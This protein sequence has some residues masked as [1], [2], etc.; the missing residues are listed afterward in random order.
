MKKGVIK[1][2]TNIWFYIF[3]AVLAFLPLIVAIRVPETIIGKI[4]ACLCV[5]IGTFGAVASIY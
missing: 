3:W 4:I 1:M 5:L 2:F